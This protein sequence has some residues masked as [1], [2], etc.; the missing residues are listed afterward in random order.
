MPD[1]M[2]TEAKSYH[3]GQMRHIIRDEQKDV[4][5]RLGFSVHRELRRY[6]NDSLSFRRAWFMDGRLMAV[7]GVTGPAI[8]STGMAWLA[9]AR[10]TGA[11]PVA[12]VR[13]ARRQMEDM[14]RTRRELV[15]VILD[16]DDASLRFAIFLGFVPI[17]YLGSPPVSRFGRRNMH[18][19]CEFQDTGRVPVGTGTGLVMRLDLGA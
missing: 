10:D 14:A 6:F 15:T 1:F 7:F 8:A 5:V 11:H 3:C 17:G 12:V 13:E 16:D 9:L 4:I 18:V 2:V 19:E